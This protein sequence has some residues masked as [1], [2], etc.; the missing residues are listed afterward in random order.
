[1]SKRDEQRIAALVKK[2]AGKPAPPK[3]DRSV[4]YDDT[5][6]HRNPSEDAETRRLFKEMKRREF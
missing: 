3:R 2:H 5:L 1:M 4:Q 6:Q